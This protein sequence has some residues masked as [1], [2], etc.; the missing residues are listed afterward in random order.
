MSVDY[1]KEV[2]IRMS[3]RKIFGSQQLRRDTAENWESKNP[4]IKDGEFIAVVCSD[5]VV[6]HKTGRGEKTYNELPFD[7]FNG[8]SSSI[9][10]ETIL[11]ASAWN[12]A[13]QII[14]DSRIGHERNGIIGLSDTATDEQ[15]DV[16]ASAE[17]RIAEQSRNS[18]LIH[19]D[20]TIPNCDIPISIVLLPTDNTSHIVY[21]TLMASKWVNNQQVIEIDGLTENQ[22]GVISI[23]RDATD[24]QV[25]I[26]RK[27]SLRIID[28]TDG[29]L[30]VTAGGTAPECDIPVLIMLIP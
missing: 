22:N 17:L 20:G 30:T 15:S 12:N 3:A 16:A 9:L 25:K 11:L 18:L 28:Q 1:K 26:A 27:A 23:A 14:T 8:S 2:R 7:N 4:V 6:R 21:A 24:E 5:G 19:A 29:S 13:E 10:I